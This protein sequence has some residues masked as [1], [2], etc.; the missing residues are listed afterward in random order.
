MTTLLHSFN[1]TER[2]KEIFVIDLCCG[3]GGLSLAAKSIGMKPIIGIDTDTSAI[4]T[5]SNN[6][7][8]ALAFEGDITD[9]ETIQKVHEHIASVKS[10]TNSVI[11][12]SGPP[13]QGFSMAGPR[14]S[15]DPRNQVLLA[16]A[17]AISI[18]QPDMALIENVALVTGSKNKMWINNLEK[19]ISD[20]GYEMCHVELNAKDYGLAQ[21]RRRVFFFITKKPLDSDEVKEFLQTLYVSP[22]TVE[23]ILSDLPDAP[24]R[25]DK[26]VD[27][28]DKGNPSN[29]FA[30][31]HS[32]KVKQK[33]AKIE[34][35]KGPLSYRK[36]DP[37]EIAGT[38]VS[39][40]RAPPAHYLYSRSIT[41]REA[42]RLQG[43]PDNFK[44]HGVFGN[45]MTQ[46]TNAVPPPLGVAA[47]KALLKFAR[48]DI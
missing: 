15:S 31:R 33:I 20:A 23:E 42:A 21:S 17:S 5:Y 4:K 22:V 19:S 1:E 37:N 36:L 27:S 3:M 48:G 47:L 41:V 14:D 44:V 8:E 24:I 6:F 29:H 39:G 28:E 13:C 10:D 16:V 11:V 18:I 45:Q 7:S 38:L 43:F 30:M 2:Q 32:N 12:I 26:Y 9:P 46:V 34:H 35:G 40:H 25:P